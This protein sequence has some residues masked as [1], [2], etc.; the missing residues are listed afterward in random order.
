MAKQLIV[1]SPLVVLKMKDGS[2]VHIYEGGP[3]PAGADQDHVQHLIEAGMILKAEVVEVPAT[4]GEPEPEA[5]TPT[6]GSSKADW[7]AYATAEA[8]GEDRLTT[9]DAEKLNRDELAVKYLGA[10]GEA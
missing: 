8:R 9:E 4:P 3:V 1:S 2:R 10:K 5:S 7:V 6:R